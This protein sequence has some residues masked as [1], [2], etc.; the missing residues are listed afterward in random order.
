MED[1]ADE[2]PTR[3]YRGAIV[4]VTILSPHPDDAVLSL[5]HVLAG[6]GDVG[7][8]N[9]FAGEPKATAVGWWDSIT[10]ASDPR[11]R[12]AERWEEDRA[13]LALAGREPVNL[14]F[15]DGQYRPGV[16]PL[17]PLVA[18]IE[19][20]AP[21]GPLL[22]PSNI[23]G[24]HPDHGLVRDAALALRE[25]GR[26]VSLYADLPHATR[27]G[28]PDWTAACDGAGA[29]EVHELDPEAE[30]RKREA[31]AAY[32]SQL[33]ALERMFELGEHPERLRY[34]VVWPLPGA[35]P[36]RRSRSRQ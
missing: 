29:P 28:M 4:P 10:G 2:S 14:E 19:A 3:R 20:A 31:I 7:V 18:A 13:A 16:Q 24:D 23:A 1:D 5:W 12:M 36:A 22:A 27:K 6:P 9:V 17:G 35:S 33:S 8:V 34:E 15:I 25:R 32:A 30:R 11:K 21:E 26:D